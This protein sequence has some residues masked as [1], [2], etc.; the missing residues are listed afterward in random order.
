MVVFVIGFADIVT[1]VVGSLA[2]RYLG[3][4]D[5]F[6][7]SGHETEWNQRRRVAGRRV[8]EKHARE[9]RRHQKNLY[10]AIGKVAF[11]EIERLLLFAPKNAL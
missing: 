8:V 7:V 1:A 6:L 2:D 5:Q 9:A 10:P 3:F 4:L 11:M